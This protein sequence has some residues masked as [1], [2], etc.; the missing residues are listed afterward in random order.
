MSIKDWLMGLLSRGE[1]PEPD[2]NAL[3]EV[4]NATLIDAPMIIAALNDQGID[5]SSVDAFDPVTA[6]TRTRIM[7]RRSDLPAARELLE[8]VR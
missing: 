6:L 3:V 1:A 4:E 2:P 5:A 7:V 8:R